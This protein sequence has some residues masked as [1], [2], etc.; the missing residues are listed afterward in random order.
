MLPFSICLVWVFGVMMRGVKT[1]SDRLLVVVLLLA[2]IYFFCD[3]NF[4][5]RY[6]DSKMLVVLD[7]ISQFV[8]LAFFPMACIYIRSLADDSPVGFSAYLL[9]LP[10]LLL[11]TIACV[12][13][14]LLGF[15]ESAR[16]LQ[17]LGPER[18]E[19]ASI[20]VLHRAQHVVC[21][22]AYNLAQ[23]VF[24]FCSMVYIIFHLVFDK[25]SFT[26]LVPFFKGNKPSLVSNMVCI[27][28]VFMFLICGIR[29]LLGRSWLIDHK[30]ISA[31]LSLA[32]SFFI[33]L[34]GYVVAVPAL[35]GG[36]INI[37]RL[38]H[39]FDAMRQPRQE[40]L[41]SINSGPVANMPLGGYE[42]LSKSFSDVMLEQQWFLRPDLTIEELSSQ[43]ATNRTYISKLVNIQYGMPFRD[44][45]N[46]LRIDYSKTL[47]LDEPDAS[48]DYIAPKSGFNSASQ[49]IRKFK[50]LEQVTPTTWRNQHR[51]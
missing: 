6:V 38:M 10:S 37:E 18:A 16:L 25:F 21:T 19:L 12:V 22:N 49:F 17:S 32:L 13:Y 14:G 43:L 7:I 2:C 45:V 11:G 31:L 41:D 47:M 8:T 30:A 15:E 20:D 27:S 42:K 24:M 46:K 3:A 26:H 40:Y 9:L 23:L 29:I 5:S 34:I 28:F 1:Y 39:P 48:I 4:V 50:E 36:Y 44:Y 51:R 33:F 35:P